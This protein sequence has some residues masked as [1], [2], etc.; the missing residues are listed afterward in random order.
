MQIM[1]Y[2]HVHVVYILYITFSEAF[3][4]VKK[5]MEK[6]VVIIQSNNKIWIKYFVCWLYLAKGISWTRF[7]KFLK[8]SLCYEFACFS[9]IQSQWTKKVTWD[10]CRVNE[11]SMATVILLYHIIVHGILFACI[12]LI[13]LHGENRMELWQFAIN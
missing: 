6:H 12:N 13:L 2:I 4:Q 9:V 7:H 8:I 1:K 5:L 10:N 3:L 11:V